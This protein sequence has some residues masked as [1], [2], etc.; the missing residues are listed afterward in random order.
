M[1]VR[2]AVLHI[3]WVTCTF[4]KTSL[5]LKDIQ[6]VPILEVHMM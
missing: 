3:G 6:Y 5:I 4:V 1:I 2:G